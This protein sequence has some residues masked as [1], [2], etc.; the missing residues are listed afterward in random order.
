MAQSPRAG[1]QRRSSCS[2]RSTRDSQRGG[3]RRS[4]HRTPA[5]GSLGRPDRAPDATPNGR[6]ARVSPGASWR[7]A[8]RSSCRRSAR[9]RCSCIARGDGGTDRARRSA[10]CRCRFRASASLRRPQHRLSVRQVAQLRPGSAR[11]PGRGVDVRPGAPAA[12]DGRGRAPAAARREHPSQGGAEAALRLLPHHRH[13]RSDAAGLRADLARRLLEHHRAHPRRI[14]HRQGADRPRAPLQ[15]AASKKRSSRSVAPRSPIPSS[16]RSC[17]ATSGA[18]SRGRRL[19]RRA[20]SSSP[21]GAR[22][23]STRSATSICRR[24]S[25]C[26]GSCRRRSSSASAATAPV[27]STSA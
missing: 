9:N 24:R 17:S 20:V 22:S 4:R 19:A 1:F 13:Q 6:W 7:A 23:S 26:S 8:S 10:S 5:G 15:L 27:K 16:S 25:S 2:T 3:P 12:A 18:R 11:V 21:R 14:R